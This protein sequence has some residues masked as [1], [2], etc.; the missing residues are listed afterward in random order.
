MSERVLRYSTVQY[1]VYT[2]ASFSEGRLNSSRFRTK[3]RKAAQTQPVWNSTRN[4]PSVPR[5]WL[6]LTIREPA[7]R[8]CCIVSATADAIPRALHQR[9]L[10][11]SS[12]SLRQTSLYRS[13]RIT[14]C[15]VHGLGV[16]FTSV[17]LLRARLPLMLA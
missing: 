9:Q 1:C 12:H 16:K 13:C 3:D 4:S 5:H 14:E 15:R 10:W 7:Y 17:F 2:V 6:C 8:K 11:C